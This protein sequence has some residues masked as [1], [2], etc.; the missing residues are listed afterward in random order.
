M[1]TQAIRGLVSQAA[2][3]WHPSYDKCADQRF[4][5]KCLRM[6]KLWSS[7]WRVA[8]LSHFDHSMLRRHVI[9]AV[10]S[11]SAGWVPNWFAW[12]LLCMADCQ[13]GL[14]R[15]VQA[16]TGQKHSCADLKVFTVSTLTST[17]DFDQPCHA[18]WEKNLGPASFQWPSLCGD[19]WPLY[20]HG[21]QS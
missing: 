8:L 11:E 17:G 1:K 12:P 13:G 2:F 6:V 4:D 21:S 19:F 10:Y 7:A 14:G 20:V 16:R 5:C 3:P 15:W 18:A 9:R